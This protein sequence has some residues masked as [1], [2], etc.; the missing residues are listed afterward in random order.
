MTLLSP[1]ALHDRATPSSRTTVAPGEEK[2][3]EEEEG[4]GE[5]EEEEEWIWSSSS[6]RRF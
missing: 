4:E 2:G 1:L 6:S 5:W 3:E